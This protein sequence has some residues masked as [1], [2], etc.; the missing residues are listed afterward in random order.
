MF[1][2]GPTRCFKQLQEDIQNHFGKILVLEIS[3]SWEKIIVWKR[4][5]PNNPEDPSSTFFKFLNMGSISCIK[6]EMEILENLEYGINLSK[7]VKWTMRVVD[8]YLQNMKCKF[9]KMGSISSRNINWT[10]VNTIE[11]TF[12]FLN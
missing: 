4:R 9:G 2:C 5:G 8:Q 7:K 10:L 6:H 1:K 3:K 11:W 12:N